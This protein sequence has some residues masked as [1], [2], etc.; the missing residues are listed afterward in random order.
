MTSPAA[1]EAELTDNGDAGASWPRFGVTEGGVMGVWGMPGTCVGAALVWRTQHAA[2][3][4]AGSLGRRRHLVYPA[5][6]GKGFEVWRQ[7]LLGS[8]RAIP[9]SR[10]RR[11]KD[12]GRKL[13][14]GRTVGDT[15][16]M[17]HT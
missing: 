14:V 12:S 11:L 9:G 4:E 3:W 5:H 2:V 6:G 8:T 7:S 13:A 16:R 17:S 15:M 10:R 1:G